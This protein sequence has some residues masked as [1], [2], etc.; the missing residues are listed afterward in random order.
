MTRFWAFS[1]GL[2]HHRITSSPATPPCQCILSL[3]ENLLFLSFPRLQ[4]ASSVHDE[5]DILV[6]CDV[7]IF[8]WLFEYMHHKSSTNKTKAYP[9]NESADDFI[10]NSTLGGLEESRGDR[11]DSGKVGGEEAVTV[12]PPA[13]EVNYAVYASGSRRGLR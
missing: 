12:M 6:H 13:L 8:E 9:G 2:T 4:Q 1:E 7:H 5:I 3:I 11:S 10:E